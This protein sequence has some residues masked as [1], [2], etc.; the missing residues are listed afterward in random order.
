MNGETSIE[1]LDQYL[2]HAEQPLSFLFRGVK[3]I[4]KHTLIP[5]VARDWKEATF[6][7]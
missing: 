4:K 2:K 1:T 3:D 5:S 7:L 6:P